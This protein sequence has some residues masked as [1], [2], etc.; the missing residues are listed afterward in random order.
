MRQNFLSLTHL[1][2][3]RSEHAHRAHAHNMDTCTRNGPAT[4]CA[5]YVTD[6]AKTGSYGRWSRGTDV[7]RKG[8]VAMR[9]KKFLRNLRSFQ[10][11]S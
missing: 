10:K 1:C 11:K 5:P 4:R 7:D 6:C 9:A 2:V 8:G 3:L